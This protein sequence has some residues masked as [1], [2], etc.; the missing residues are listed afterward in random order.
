MTVWTYNGHEVGGIDGD[1]ATLAIL[2]DV[3]RDR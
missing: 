2:G 3:L 1:G